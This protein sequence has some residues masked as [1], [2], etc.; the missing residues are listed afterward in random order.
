MDGGEKTGLFHQEN[1]VNTAVEANAKQK[2]RMLTKIDVV[3]KLSPC[4]FMKSPSCSS[5]RR[6]NLS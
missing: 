6:G 4:F 2:K 3:V 5:A 1:Q